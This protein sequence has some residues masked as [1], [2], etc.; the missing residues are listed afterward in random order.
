M[1]GWIPIPL[2]GAPCWEPIRLRQRLAFPTVFPIY[3]R[4]NPREPYGDDVRVE[5][6]LHLH[7][8]ARGEGAAAAIDLRASEGYSLRVHEVIVETAD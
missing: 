2:G 5:V 1:L 3:G 4:T 7:T 8:T 6:R